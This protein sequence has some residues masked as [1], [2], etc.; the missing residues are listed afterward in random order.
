MVGARSGHGWGM[1]WARL[2]YKTEI[3]GSWLGQCWGT[4]H[5]WGMV[6]AGT[7]AA[8]LGHA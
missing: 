8:R 6:E 5:G 7:I 1:V 3:S 4:G 2:G